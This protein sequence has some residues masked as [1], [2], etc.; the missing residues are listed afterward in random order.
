MMIDNKLEPLQKLIQKP[1]TDIPVDPKIEFQWVML[2]QQQILPQQQPFANEA[3][4]QDT[5][6]QIIPEE[7]RT[8]EVKKNETPCSKELF[9]W[10]QQFQ[11]IFNKEEIQTMASGEFQTTMTNSPTFDGCKFS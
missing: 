10:F 9:S 1:I 7:D 8:K 11:E 6:I 2:N 4:E 3:P 5:L